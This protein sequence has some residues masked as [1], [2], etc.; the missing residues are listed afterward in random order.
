M[1]HIRLLDQLLQKMFRLE[2]LVLAEQ[3]KEM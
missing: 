1:V 3:S 2:Q